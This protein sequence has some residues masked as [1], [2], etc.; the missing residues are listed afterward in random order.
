MSAGAKVVW[1]IIGLV[2]LLTV[3]VLLGGWIYWLLWNHALIPIVAAC[4]GT[5]GKISFA[6]GVGLWLIVGTL[7]PMSYNR[8]RDKS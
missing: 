4:G 1:T 7:K 3:V 6:N 8:N 5:I 2:V